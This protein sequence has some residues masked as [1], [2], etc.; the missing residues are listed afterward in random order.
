MKPRKGDW[1]KVADENS[2]ALCLCLRCGAQL[3]ILTPQNLAIIV[4]SMR[5]FLKLHKLCKARKTV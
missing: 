4:G 3:E 2:N 5:A 1:I